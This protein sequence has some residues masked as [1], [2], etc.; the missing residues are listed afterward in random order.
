MSDIEN[1]ELKRL[2]SSMI[3]EHNTELIQAIS[4]LTTEIENHRKAMN[5]RIE[6]VEDVLSRVEDRIINANR[7]SGTS[8]DL[9]TKKQSK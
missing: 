6:S 2:I 8:A 4:M 7:K 5:T 9:E 1:S 3:I